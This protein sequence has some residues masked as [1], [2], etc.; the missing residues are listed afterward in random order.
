VFPST[1]PE[2]PSEAKDSHLVV[3]RAKQGSGRDSERTDN[4]C[5]F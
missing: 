2:L 5:A 4:V 3:P 1:G